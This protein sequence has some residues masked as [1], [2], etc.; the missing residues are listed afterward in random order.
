MKKPI[1]SPLKLALISGLLVGLSYPPF[2]GILALFAFIPLIRVWLTVKIIDSIKYSYFA[3]IIANAI[4]LYW[5]GLNTGASFLPVMISL[6][7]AILYLS[8]FWAIL[9]GAISWFKDRFNY[10]EY[11]IPFL[12]VS[13]EAINFML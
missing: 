2:F 13:M 5:I 3:A 9:G 1:F 7:A 4:S 6:V 12:W 11:L 8:I 10:V